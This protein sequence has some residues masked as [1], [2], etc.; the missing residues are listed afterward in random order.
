MDALFESII[1][2]FSFNFG[3][4]IDLLINNLFFLFGFAAF[5]HF[6]FEGRKPFLILLVMIFTVWVWESW[7]SLTG[8]V[9]FG[10]KTLGLYYLT[11]VATLTFVEN[12]QA[13]KDKFVLISTMQGLVAIFVA[14]LI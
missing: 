6:V 10:A 3:F 5:V 7:G 13:L 11:K 14:Q 2:I 9:L 8:V 12:S 1:A 4:L